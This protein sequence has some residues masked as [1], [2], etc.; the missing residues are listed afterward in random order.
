MEN[1]I[2]KNKGGVFPAEIVFVL[3]DNPEAKAIEKAKK[4]GVPV[5][6]VPRK[7]YANRSD[8]EREVTHYLESKQIDYILLAG[9]MRILSPAFVKRYPD[10]MINIHPSLLPQFPGAQGIQDA[11]E[12]KVKETGVTVH[13]VTEEVDGGPMILQRKVP[14]HSNDTLESLTKRI[15]EV[16][17]EI[18][19]EA[20]RMLLSRQSPPHSL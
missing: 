20:L 13:Y 12:A 2:L 7:N 1:L 8:F 10:R 11:F 9:F 16:E 6:I 17:Y 4:L 19:P 5:M 15:H 14:V 18:Y 3:T